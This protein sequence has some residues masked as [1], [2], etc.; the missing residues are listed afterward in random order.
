MF[1]YVWNDCVFGGNFFTLMFYEWPR[2]GSSWTRWYVPVPMYDGRNY[3]TI[4]KKATG[5]KPVAWFCGRPSDPKLNL[6]FCSA[7]MHTPYM[8]NKN[9]VYDNRR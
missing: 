1:L 5:L 7:R 3:P 8:Q 4:K 6:A 9:V 2:T